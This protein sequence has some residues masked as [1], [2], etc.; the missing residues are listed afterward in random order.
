MN[1]DKIIILYFSATS[2]TKLIMQQCLKTFNSQGYITETVRIEDLDEIKRINFNNVD[3][4]GI[5]YPCYAFDFPR[6]VMVPALDLI[7]KQ[8]KSKPTFII[9]TYCI[10]SGLSVKSIVEI[11]KNKNFN[12]I[13]VGGF[14]C[15]SP[16][17]VNIT[18]KERTSGFK[19]Y[20]LRKLMKFEDNILLKASDFGEETIK[21]LNTYK[22]APFQI[23]VKVRIISYLGYRFAKF[24]EKRIF[25]NY[26]IDI[27]KC[28]SCEMCVKQCPVGNIE[29][30]NG[31]VGFLDKNDCL[32]CMKCIS[33]CPKD[34]ITLGDKTKG[35]DRYNKKMREKLIGITYQWK[36]KS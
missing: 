1:R 11:L 20:F 35:M 9:N 13:S 7:Q 24:N 16:G 23:P 19:Y 32:R 30:V 17:F 36:P 33:N 28:I 31:K 22:K 27:N 8:N 6:K 3:L 15:P 2:N 14:K 5:A 4:L 10:S 12:T 25:N 29:I 34:A 21:L 26:K 18:S